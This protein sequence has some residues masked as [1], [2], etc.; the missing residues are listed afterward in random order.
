[1]AG[2]ENNLE[3]DLFNSDFELELDNIED[4]ETSTEEVDDE[5][6]PNNDGNPSED[7]ADSESV[8]EDSEVSSDEGSEEEES[9][10]NPNLY[11]SVAALLHEQG[12]F[13]SLDID[14]TKIE[15]LED[16]VTNFNKEV[17]SKVKDTL[18]TKIGQEGYE[19]L[20]KGIS[21][22]ELNQY[23]EQQKLL[24]E[25]KDEEIESNQDL[26]KQLIY[27]D[28]INQGLSEEK[29]LKLLKRLVDTGDEQLLVNDAKE[30]LENIKEFN[31]SEFL[32]KQQA[33]NQR[34][35]DIAKQRELH[36]EN[37][38]KSVYDTKQLIEGQEF[39]KQFQD[40][41]YRTMTNIVGKTEEGKPEN[42]LMKYR[43]EN[44]IDFDTK[45]YYLFELTN[46]FT[47]FT[48]FSTISQSKAVK[49]LERVI[50]SNSF[51]EY[52]NEDPDYLNDSNSYSGIEGDELVF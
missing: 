39:N 3:M 36:S 14:K 17:E 1:M 16:F 51:T 35:I 8:A 32:K 48:K 27:Q 25:V 13:P 45:L 41:V 33:E 31:K 26:A 49:D 47:D 34:M 43:R 30:S 6:N 15:T 21:L 37:L 12:L 19:A 18:I 46:G 20:N 42:K 2:E 38:K 29:S 22:S 52:S 5:Q 23:N 10:P 44:P 40:K 9:S 4:T 7:Q 11:S 24:A 50:R 28:Y